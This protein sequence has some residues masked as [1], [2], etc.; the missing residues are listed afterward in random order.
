MNLLALSSIVSRSVARWG[1]FISV[2]LG[3]GLALGCFFE[4]GE[5]QPAVGGSD[6]GLFAGNG[7]VAGAD[8]GGSGGVQAGSAGEPV[9]GNQSQ[10]GGGGIVGPSCAPGQKPC[11]S[12]ECKTI[13]PENGCGDTDTCNPCP[14]PTASTVNC[15]D[16]GECVVT[17]CMDGFADCDGDT[18]AGRDLST[19][20]GCEYSFGNLAS[21]SDPLDVPFRVIQLNGQRDDWMG[22]ATQRLLQPCADCRDDVTPPISNENTRPP[23]RDLDAYFRMA[24]DND[25][26]YVLGEAYDDFVFADGSSLQGQLDECNQGAECEDSLMM[27]ID[28]RADGQFMND[29]HRIFFGLGGGIAHP[30][31]G[32]PGPDDVAFVAATNG[33][34]CYRVEAQFSWEYV[35]GTQNGQPVGGQFPP[36]AGQTYKFAVAMSDFDRSPTNPDEVQRQ[37]LVFYES[38]GPDYRFNFSGFGAMQLSGGE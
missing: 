10:G 18:D 16:Q 36:A 23:A 28:G 35:V 25:N 1:R 33:P 37:S 34:R 29:D 7:G 9:G 32:A 6:G 30:S 21:F 20:N 31:Q 14:A 17:G 19:S 38:P 2:G 27:A 12:G 11:A 26:L 24:W 22:V 5:L 8:D 15:S 4:L 3:T 13:S